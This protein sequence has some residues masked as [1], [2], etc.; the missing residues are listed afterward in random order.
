MLVTIGI[1]R[2]ASGEF[3]AM[4]PDFPGCA[5]VDRDADSAFARL[6]LLIEGDLAD[7][8]LAGRPEPELNDLAHW[9][10][11]SPKT[12]TQWSQFH[13]NVPHIEA[14]ARHQ[15][16]RQVPETGGPIK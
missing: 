12:A 9:R 1:H 5:L 8:Y 15:R 14:V 13:I 2:L 3:E 16:G 4:A 7:R 11:H 6:R 10:S